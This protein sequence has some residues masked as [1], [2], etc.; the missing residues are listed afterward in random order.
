M[1]RMITSPNCYFIT[2]ETFQELSERTKL[3]VVEFRPENGYRPVIV[4]SPSSGAAEQASKSRI[5][6]PHHLQ[7]DAI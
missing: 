1:G 3:N 4:A 5:T 6:A 7:L 2:Q